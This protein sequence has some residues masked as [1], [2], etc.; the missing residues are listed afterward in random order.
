MGS[1]EQEQ[2]ALTAVVPQR[3]CG[4]LRHWQLHV[5]VLKKCRGDTH[6]AAGSATQMHLPES[7]ENPQPHC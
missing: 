6:L 3:H 5:W 4:W 1:E 2:V 7:K